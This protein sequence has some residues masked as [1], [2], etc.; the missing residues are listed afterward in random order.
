MTAIPANPNTTAAAIDRHWEETQDG[1]NRPHLG[2]SQIGNECLRALWYG[3]R[4]AIKHQHSGRLLRLFNRGQEEES[5]FCRDLRAIGCRVYERDPRT[6]KQFNFR[7]VGGHFGGSCDAIV[8]GIP[9]SMRDHVCEM[10]T[11]NSKS[12]AD[13]ARHGVEKSKPAHFHQMQ[14]YMHWSGCKRALYLAVNKDDDALY[15][16]RVRYD[17]AIAEADL[18]KAR[19]IIEAE[20]PPARMSED[21]SF[22]LCKWCDF[23]GVCHGGEAAEANC[24]TC[25]H[26]TPTLDGDAQWH[27]SKYHA[28]I[29]IDNQRIGGQCPNHLMIPELVPYA[30]AVDA[31]DDEN[32]IE[33]H[34]GNSVVFRNGPKSKDCYLSRELRGLPAT[35]ACDETV[36]A[37]RAFEGFDAEVV[38]K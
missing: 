28:D 3:F 33:Y 24:R 32:W 27:C 22:Y 19:H 9:E 6:G 35:M 13:L 23:H 10:K 4:W 8:S 21:P 38:A 14:L 29:D 1:G 11:H 17:K 30:E 36:E 5:R 26:I 18:D 16:E 31:S 37:F 25:V 15:T 7:D 20:R 12:F 34:M 2:A